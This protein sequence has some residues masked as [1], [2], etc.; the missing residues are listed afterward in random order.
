MKL[1]PRPYQE[2]A[3]T[4]VLDYARTHP[5]G[6]CL[7]Y[8]PTRGG[9]TLTGALLMQRMA[10]RRRR[11]GL[12]FVHRGELLDDA[13]E[14]LLDVGIPEAQIGEIQ[15]GRRTNDAALIQ[16][17]SEATLD[18][19]D[20]PPA[21]FIIT[22]ESHRDTAARRRRIR[23]AYGSA[24]HCGLSATP[25]PPAHRDLGEDFDTLMVVVQPS[26]LIH[27]GYLAVPTVY[28]PE[29]SALPSLRGVRVAEGD[30]AEADLEPLL[31]TRALLDRQV[32]E[33]GRLAE[34]R[35][36][37]AFPVTIAHSKALVARFHAHGVSARHL[38]GT[39]SPA[40]RRAILAGLRDGKVPVVSS[41]SVL[42]E[43][44]NIH[45]VKC[46]L[47]ARPTLSLPL[48]IQQTMRCATPWRD[49]RPRLLDMMGN[50]YRHGFPFADREWSL[51]PTES[52]RLREPV[53]L[54]RCKGC[55]A[56]QAA[57]ATAC[58][59]CGRAFKDPAA[60]PQPSIPDVEL[61]LVELSPA[62]ARLTAE[63]SKLV[64]YAVS[65]GFE[66]PETWADAVLATK[67]RGTAP[68]GAAARE[69]A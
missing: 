64:A 39:T 27:D 57:T 56:V 63:R 1:I 32:R 10:V 6:R 5:T 20:L 38:D 26:E 14:H 59:A 49:V 34:W 41:V 15:A 42:S 44:I 19:R 25:R 65:R 46:V 55:G 45:E 60:R 50:C 40:D 48:Y 16:V 51:H 17:A 66:A 4:Q 52:G 54:R 22:D 11:P 53:T 18:R 28:A 30:Y 33:W 61:E 29:R 36:T 8:I 9:K 62:R 47:H 35:T 21:A 24:F 68:S 37:M 7:I 13:V 43:G 69:V 31:A 3:V 58:E 67:Y 23:S 12:W 2:H